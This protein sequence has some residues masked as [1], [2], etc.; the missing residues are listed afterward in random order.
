MNHGL[1][2]MVQ[3]MRTQNHRSDRFIRGEATENSSTLL[4]APTAKVGHMGTVAH[5]KIEN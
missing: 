4:A 3:G 2:G 1:K 5:K